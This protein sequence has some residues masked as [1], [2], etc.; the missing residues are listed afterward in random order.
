MIDLSP[1]AA[2]TRRRFLAMAAASV[3]ASA[4]PLRSAE[5]QPAAQPA[6]KYLRRNITAHGFPAKVLTSYSAAITA[7]LKLPPSDPRNWYRNAFVHTLDCPHGNWWFP[8]WHRGYLGYFELTCRELSGDPDFALPFWDWTAMPRIPAQFFQGV[9]NPSN[10]AYISSYNDF[11]A[12]LSNPMSALWSSFTSAQIQQLSQRG[13]NSINDVWTAVQGDPMFF[14]SPQTRALTAASPGLDTPT[15]RA[16]ALSTITKALAPKDFIGFGSDKAP[17]HSQSAGFGILEGQPHNNVHNCISG[18]MEDMLSPVDPIFFLHHGNIDRLWDVW[19]RKQQKLNLPIVP[20]GS[21]LQAWTSEPF[22]FFHD[23]KGNAIP[24]ATAG[25]FAAIG[26]FNYAYEKGSGES[27]VA[28]A[29]PQPNAPAAQS[30]SGGITSHALALGSPSLG[31]VPVPAA[32]LSAATVAAGGPTVFARVTIE[33]PPAVHGFRFN[34]YVNPPEN[35]SAL[36]AESPSYAGTI[37][38]FGAHHHDVPVTFTVPLSDTLKALAANNTLKP[39]QPL[40]IVVIPEPRP[41]LSPAV[42]GANFKSTL[43]SVSVG[44]F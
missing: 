16:V 24:Q 3:A 35:T 7:M 32:V 20:T 10:P 12:Q 34:V 39:N 1:S 44:T 21:D 28:K 4:C 41:T 25:D 13:Y 29:V 40:N 27:V 38:F 15:K 30:F 18:L 22:L 33:N 37:E 14:P 19:T 36:N 6:A 5:A 26:K 31:T 8:V 11:F 42:A 23:E 2:I 43:A 9:L 17:Q